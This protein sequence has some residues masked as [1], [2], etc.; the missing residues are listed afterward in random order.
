MSTD[1]GSSFNPNRF[2]TGL[3]HHTFSSEDM[4][5]DPDNQNEDVTPTIKSLA[6]QRTVHRM[7]TSPVFVVRKPSQK[8][9]G[10]A[11][12]KLHISLSCLILICSNKQYWKNLSE[13]EQFEEHWIK[14]SI[15]KCSIC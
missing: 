5:P 14:K 4:S 11:R 15:K 10:P 2:T 9:L 6:Y 1:Q 12:S 7:D 3:M 13:N 8:R